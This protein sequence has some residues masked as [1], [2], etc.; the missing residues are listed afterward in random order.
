MRF[1][2]DNAKG[3][4]SLLSDSDTQT[5]DQKIAGDQFGAFIVVGQQGAADV[6]D[7]SAGRGFVP[8]PVA[9]L[10]ARRPG[11]AGVSAASS[12]KALR[13]SIAKRSAS[14]GDMS[15]TGLAGRSPRSHAAT[16]SPHSAGGNPLKPTVLRSRA[17]QDCGVG[18]RQRAQFGLHCVRQFGAE[19]APTL[20]RLRGRE[21]LRRWEWLLPPPLAGE[22]RGGGPG[23]PIRIG[24]LARIVVGKIHDHAPDRRVR[25]ASPARPQSPVSE[26][27]RRLAGRS[28][29]PVRTAPTARVVAAC[30]RPAVGSARSR[31]TAIPSSSR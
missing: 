3:D 13:S 12:A 5:W 16:Y 19:P 18:R 30:V 1:C 20:P 7:G 4:A 6:A 9:E 23:G 21:Y 29:G 15:A 22:G 8:Q 10:L 2:R 31:P 17:T 14:P 25:P 27:P 24:R 26:T 28:A 11:S